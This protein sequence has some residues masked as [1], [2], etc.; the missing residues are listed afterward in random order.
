MNLNVLTPLTIEKLIKTLLE[1]WQ[2]SDD[3]VERN[4]LKVQLFQLRRHY[5]SLTGHL[6][7][8]SISLGD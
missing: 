6:L 5:H 7:K 3:G 8:L 4:E 2:E 1:C